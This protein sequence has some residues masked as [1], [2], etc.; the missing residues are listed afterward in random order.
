MTR[1]HE[2]RRATA[3]GL[4]SRE[5][6][7]ALRVEC[8]RM[9]RLLAER[10]VHTVGL[11][12]AADDVAVPPIAIELGR[13]LADKSALIGVVD[14]QGSWMDARLRV[15]GA[16]SDGTP[17]AT[18][19]LLDNLGVLTPPTTGTDSLLS[20]LRRIV[21][22][23]RATFTHLVID[24]TGFDHAGEQIAACDLLDAVVLV[25]RSGRTTAH[26]VRRWLRDLPPDRNLGVLLTGV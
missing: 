25:A 12:P 1:I 14:A 3:L 17:T 20:R 6:H 8:A 13:A 10:L 24:L 22:E 19:W 11:A 26:Q 16:P 9:A 7:P 4:S 15:E 21:L 2:E 18:T 23:T 5:E